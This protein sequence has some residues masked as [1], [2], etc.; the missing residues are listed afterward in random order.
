MV[1]AMRSFPDAWLPSLFIDSS[2]EPVSTP[3]G[4]VC[5]R[6]K[7]AIADGD[8]GLILCVGV[9]EETPSGEVTL[10]CACWEAMVEGLRVDH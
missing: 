8:A 10:H 5:V 2:S 6:C 4:A 3:I 7:V 1:G 9:S